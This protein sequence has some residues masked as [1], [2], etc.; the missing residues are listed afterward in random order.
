VKVSVEKESPAERA[1]Y[2]RRSFSG[3][4]MNTILARLALVV[5][6]VSVANTGTFAIAQ[7]ASDLKARCNQ[8][9][10]FYDWYG[11]SRSEN[12]DGARHHERMRAG[13]ECGKGDYQEGIA[14]MEDLLRR[15]NF[16]VPPPTAVAQVPPS[17]GT[18]VR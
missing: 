4:N 15:K 12:T 5:S 9:M 11:A 3:R 8:L 1:G 17:P 13:M 6:V 16:D 7:S 14:R 10:S 18:P 2:Q